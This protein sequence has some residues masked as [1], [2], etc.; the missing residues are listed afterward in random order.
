MV[1]SLDVVRAD[2]PRQ[3]DGERDVREKR[4]HNISTYGERLFG[5][6]VHLTRDRTLSEDLV[7][8][9]MAKALAAARVPKDEP[10]VRAWLFRILRNAYIDLARRERLVELSAEPPEP[11]DGGL[12]QPYDDRLVNV[13]TVRMAIA[14]LAPSHREIIALIDI[15]GFNYAET[16]RFLG[17][18]D[19][20]VMSRISRARRA[21]AR[22]IGDTNL[23]ALPMRR[24]GARR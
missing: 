19:G 10:A 5:Y 9:T 22:I 11:P 21:L 3:S 6:A 13:L 23:H 15:A 2:W 7:Q 12:D 17:L 1:Y 4:R 14:K 18:P 8:E 20:T 16:A 24:A